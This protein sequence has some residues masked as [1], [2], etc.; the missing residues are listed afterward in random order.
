MDML[1]PFIAGR[2]PSEN[3][4]L[5]RY[6]EPITRFGVYEMVSRYAAIAAQTV[7]SI[8]KEEG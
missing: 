2:N 4:F 6:G 3:I 5:N 1:K 7:S 8:K